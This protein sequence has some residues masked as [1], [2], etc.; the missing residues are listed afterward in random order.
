MTGKTVQGHE[1]RRGKKKSEKKLLSGCTG[2]EDAS[3]SPRLNSWRKV[4]R[5][6]RRG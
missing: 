1:K 6:K 4:T 5:R 3:F 2:I